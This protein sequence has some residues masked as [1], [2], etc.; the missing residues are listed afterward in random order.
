MND[1]PF[2]F[3]EKKKISQLLI[4][5]YW[6]YVSYHTVGRVTWR[7]EERG[8][9][10]DVNVQVP[11]LWLQLLGSENSR[12]T[13]T[14]FEE[15]WKAGTSA[16]P[17]WVCLER[18]QVSWRRSPSSIGLLPAGS[19]RKVSRPM[20]QDSLPSYPWSEC[21]CK[22]PRSSHLPQWEYVKAW[23]AQVN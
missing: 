19:W 18:L 20:Y 15:S 8:R 7:E 5:A 2:C 16:L 9:T 6:L 4:M 21:G 17:S 14:D 22:R 11:T 1:Y 23:R 12:T 10:R 3:T 13:H